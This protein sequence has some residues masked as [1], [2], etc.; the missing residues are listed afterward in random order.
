MAQK[1]MCGVGRAR[2]FSRVPG[3]PT[4]QLQALGRER[5]PLAR[6]SS[7]ASKRPSF[8]GRSQTQRERQ[9][10]FVYDNVHQEAKVRTEAPQ[11]K[12]PQSRHYAYSSPFVTLYNLKTACQAQEGIHRFRGCTKTQTH[13]QEV[14]QSA[15]IFPKTAG[16]QS[17]TLPQERA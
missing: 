11:R 5:K 9:N 14:A 16:Q 4:C 8:P 1:L 6:P 10:A 3:R 15:V 17:H 13:S 7:G 2:R 12:P